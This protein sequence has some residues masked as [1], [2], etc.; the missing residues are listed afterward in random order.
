MFCFYL[1]LHRRTSGGTDQDIVMSCTPD[2]SLADAIRLM[3]SHGLRY[4]PVSDTR[5]QRPVGVLDRDTIRT[6][7]KLSI[8]RNQVGRMAE[9]E[10]NTQVSADGG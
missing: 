6:R 1:S 8:I 5:D 10:T 2:D 4:L 3:E 9:A 7:L